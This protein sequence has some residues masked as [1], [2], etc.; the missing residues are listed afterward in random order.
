MKVDEHLEKH[1][2]HTFLNTLMKK[3]PNLQN[4]GK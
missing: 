2:C 3:S 4:E 1:I